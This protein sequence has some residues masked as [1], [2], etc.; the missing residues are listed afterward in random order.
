MSA[1]SGCVDSASSSVS[2]RLRGPAAAHATALAGDDPAQ[3]RETGLVLLDLMSA[4]FKWGGG[5]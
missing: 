4:A 3:M 1:V 2:G 5:K